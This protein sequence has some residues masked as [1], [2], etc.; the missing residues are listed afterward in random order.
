MARPKTKLW[1][2][3]PKL[4]QFEN[5][6]GLLGILAKAKPGKENR[7]KSKAQTARRKRLPRR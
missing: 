6:D 2:P 1:N 3:D 7:R 5:F 4:S